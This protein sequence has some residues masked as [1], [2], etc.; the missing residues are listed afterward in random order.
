MENSSSPSSSAPE[1]RFGSNEI[2]LSLAEWGL[3]AGVVAAVLIAAPILWRRIEPFQPGKDY[4][5]PFRLGNDYWLYARAARN[6]CRGRRIAVVGDSVVWGHYVGKDQTLS[7]YLNR[8]AGEER[9][10]NL[11]V[12]GIHPAALEGLVAYYG[13]AL[14]GRPVILQCNLLWIS[15]KRQ[16]LQAHKEFAFNHPDLV[17][18]FFPRIPCYRKPLADRLGTVIDREIPVAGWVKH[19]R[20][21]Y[22]DGKDLATWSLDHPYAAPWTCLS[23]PLPSPGEPPFPRPEAKPWTARGLARFDAAWVDLDTSIQW[24]S[25]QRVVHRLLARNARLLVILGPFNEH[26]LTARSRRRYRARRAAV[27]AWLAAAHVPHVVP[28]ALP[29]EDYADASHPLAPGYALLAERLAA[30][31]VFRRFVGS[32]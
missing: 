18:Q 20:I 7:H 15:S 2:R 11:G 6:L 9:F 28:A 24:H 19:M 1:V 26:M 16:D 25:F 29:S 30:D 27:A 8:T 17:P 12:D 10:V 31:P 3:A 21:A 23:R 22:F 5:L 13:R 4:R 14:A 32:P